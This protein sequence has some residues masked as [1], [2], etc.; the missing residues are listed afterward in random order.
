[1]SINE[2]IKKRAL[3]VDPYLLTLGVIA[4]VLAVALSAAIPGRFTDWDNFASMSIQLSELGML[5]VAMALSLLIGGIDLS[6][7]AVANLSAI[8][9]GIAIQAIAPGESSQARVYLALLAGI[10]ITLATGGI[11]GYINGLLIAKIG[12]PSILATLGTMTLVSGLA[13]GFT[14]EGSV[15]GLPDGLVAIGNGSLAAIPVP[16]LIFIVVWLA[17][18]LLVRKTAF[19]AEMILVGTS[20]K[21]AQFSG[22]PTRRII[23]GTHVIAS[24]IAA[25]TGLVSLLR[26]NSAH[27]D[28]GGSYVLL[29]ILVSVLGG[30]S[31]SGGA[32]KLIGVLWALVILQLLS[33]GFNMLLL[34]VPDGNFFRDFVWGLLL[35]LV[36]TLTALF[37][38]PKRYKH[39]SAN[40]R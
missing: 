27:A 3:A 20:L 13:F 17:V 14:N 8:L 4:L 26:T 11:I 10:I 32:G 25:L 34:F 21:V 22:I 36:M 5:S 30:V 31:V 39:R 35:L 2:M 19:G 38:A 37:R 12:V 29:A 40:K 6:I 16:F 9:A 23:I 7:V 15:S 18:D 1:M 28:Y 24:L 33:T